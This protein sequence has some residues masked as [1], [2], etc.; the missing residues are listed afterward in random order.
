MNGDGALDVSGDYWFDFGIWE[1]QLTDGIEA[2]EAP[3]NVKAEQTEDGQLTITWTGDE[4]NPGYAYNFYI[5]NKATGAIS[6]LIPASIETGA[7]RSTQDLGVALR[8]DDPS[9]MSY[10]LNAADGDYEVG[11]QTLK[12]DWTTSAF[13]KAEVSISSGI[14]ST[15]AI[16]TTVTRIYDAGGRYMGSNPD[17]L[18]HGLFVV[19]KGGIFTKVVK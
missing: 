10:T 17:N 2:P 16:P 11:V 15:K 12:N 13:T 6:Q 9:A 4:L 14:Q 3:T 19:E 18:G 1:S 5:K 8:S 7:L